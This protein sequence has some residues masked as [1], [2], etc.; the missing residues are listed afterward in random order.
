MATARQTLPQ[1]GGVQNIAQ[2][3]SALNPLFGTGKATTKTSVSSDP[4]A[5]GQADALFQQVLNGA[6]PTTIDNMVNNI[7]VRARQEFGPMLV[8]NAAS[9]NRAYSSTTLQ[10]MAS[11]AMAR[12]TGEAA[13]AKL[14]AMNTAQRTAAGLAEARL[15]SSRT[16]VQTQKTAASP[17]GKGSAALSLAAFLR[18]QLKDKPN[19]KKAP[20]EE[21]NIEEILRKAQGA[22]NSFDI[23][24]VSKSITQGSDAALPNFDIGV[25]ELG[26]TSSVDL[27]GIDLGVESLSDA[28][29][30]SAE[31]GIGFNEIDFSDA[32]IS[33]LAF[34]G[35]GMASDGINQT[36]E[37]GFVGDAFNMGAEAAEFGFLADG[38][39]DAMGGSIPFL[40]PAVSLAQGNVGG[41]LGSVVGNTILPG[42]GGVVGGFI[43]SII[44]DDCFITT[45]ATNGG[46]LDNGF[47]LSALRSFRSSYMQETPE[48]QVEMVEYYL[49]APIIV[50]RISE[51]PQAD[52]IYQKIREGFLAPAVISYMTG[53]NDRT[54]EIYKEMIHFAKQ[55]VG[56]AHSG[57]I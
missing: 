47:T 28:L 35:A 6:D 22:E 32:G 33:G 56:L 36:A 29:G 41:A 53:N 49:V 7:L 55:Q 27:S 38:A 3:I 11:E 25:S 50:K 39:G 45:A 20:V 18:N 12:A 46:E 23:A 14:D 21:R 13:K 17:M 5:V 37:F 24:D 10:Q 57:R 31:T 42:I 26:G 30:L 43:G 15:N 19:G 44:G 9:G 2:L 54:Y 16:T 34:D 8:A 51:S 52:A 48:R 4:A 40:G 1:A